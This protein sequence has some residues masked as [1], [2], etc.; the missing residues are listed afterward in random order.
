MLLDSWPKNVKYKFFDNSYEY[1]THYY[2]TDATILETEVKNN[3]N[4]VSSELNI[5]ALLLVNQIHSTKIII[6][7][8]RN[9]YLDIN[10]DGI[11]STRKHIAVGV[12]TADC[13]P[14]LITNLKG[15]FIAALHCG[16]R[17]S[18]NGIIKEFSTIIK[19]NFSNISALYAIIG[20]SISQKNYKVSK[21]LY[22]I[23]CRL[24]PNYSKLFL[25]SVNEAFFYFDLQGFV[26][27][28]LNKIGA[29][30]IPSSTSQC[31]YD[32]KNYFSW[33]RSGGVEKR[34]ILSTIYMN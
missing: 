6:D 16:W 5:E 31:S 7:D 17:G 14:V 13:V 2:K 18:A 29:I 19:T 15:D 26:T 24:D 30:V 10:A 4:A 11:I 28:E 8:G 12:L 22:E 9:D 23:F 33:R 21:E 3:I 34:R 27:L 1:S 25:K 32:N 20:P